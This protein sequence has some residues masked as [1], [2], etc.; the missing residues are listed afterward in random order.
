MG[1]MWLVFL[2]SVAALIV[3]WSRSTK[4]GALPAGTDRMQEIASY[5]HEGAMAFLQR[6]YRSLAIFIAVLFLVLCF[7]PGLGI[8]VAICFLVGALFS[9][10]T[11]YAGMQVAT[12]ANVRTANAAREGGL[13]DALSVAFSGG[14][15][16]GLSV[17]GFGLL[18]IGVLY[19]VYRDAAIVTGFG[20][21]HH[22]LLICPCRRRYLYQ[23]R[24]R[25]C[26]LGW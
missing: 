4:I 23:G 1:Y 12:K 13:N 9:L 2:S 22:R 24:R 16:M 6:E 17:V 18:G 14:L 3:A 15:V 20:L 19:Y 26:R 5:I 7:V 8:K 11:G 25:W 21:G 10:A